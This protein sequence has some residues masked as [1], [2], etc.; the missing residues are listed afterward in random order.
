MEL[1]RAKDIF[2][3][4]TVFTFF[5]FSPNAAVLSRKTLVIGSRLGIGRYKIL[6]DLDWDREG[7]KTW[8][9]HPHLKHFPEFAESLWHPLHHLSALSLEA[10]M[11]GSRAFCFLWHGLSLSSS[12]SDHSLSEVKTRKVMTKTIDLCYWTIR[13]HL[14]SLSWFRLSRKEERACWP[15]RMVI[16]RIDS[17]V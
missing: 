3:L 9:G 2:K 11:W 15:G 17:W 16:G 8:S 14:L 4:L 5:F 7:Q 1:I 12:V 10:R 6:N 13:H